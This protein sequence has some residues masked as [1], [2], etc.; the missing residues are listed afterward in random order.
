MRMKRPNVWSKKN[1][2]SKSKRSKEEKRKGSPD[3]WME[4]YDK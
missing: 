4:Y 3:E 2:T 1:L